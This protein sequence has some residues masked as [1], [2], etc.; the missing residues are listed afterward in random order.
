M[1]EHMTTLTV[2]MN[3]LSQAKQTAVLKALTEGMSI[4]AASRMTGVS[5]TTILKLLVEVGEMCEHYQNHKLRN[6]S[7]KRIEADEIWA[8]VGMK[9]KRAKIAGTGDAWTFTAI[10]ADSKL[11]VAWKVGPR[12][13]Y[14]AYDFMCDV[15]ERV[16]NR[17][18]LTTDGHGM[19]FA[20]VTAAFNDDVDYA[21]LVKRYGVDPNAP[22]RKYSP[23]I[24]LGAE[25]VWIQGSPDFEKVSTSYVERSNLS[26]RMANR[27]FTRLTNA[28]SK[29]VE[30]HAHA[31]AL[32]FF[33]YNFCKPHGTLTKAANGVKVTPAM[34]AGVTDRIWKVE[35]ILDLMNPDRMLQ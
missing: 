15:R 4:R 21:Q 32:Y 28:F 1:L 17:I 18:Q 7:C 6:L 31:V 27:R 25:K 35:E 34:A 24:C 9:Q 16:A 33:A 14:T 5:K 10:D 22:V 2:T 11:M 8:F 20:A 3:K 23:P 19:Y 30:N 26:L 13:M 29:K 12:D